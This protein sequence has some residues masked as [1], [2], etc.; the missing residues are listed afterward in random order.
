MSGGAWL[1]AGGALV[2]WFGAS[3]L[4]CKRK[5]ERAVS[6]LRDRRA[7]PSRDDFVAMLAP[8]VG[9]ATA[10][11]FWKELQVYYRPRLSPHPDDDLTGD[12]PIDPDEP[13]DWVRDYCRLHGLKVHDLAQ[14]PEA[15]AVTPRNLLGWLE[16]ER[17]RLTE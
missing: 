1:L 4:I 3:Y 14:W 7:N 8:E 9:S 16:K 5:W 2:T 12:L 11:W 17:S 15:L 10:L 13:D 6:L